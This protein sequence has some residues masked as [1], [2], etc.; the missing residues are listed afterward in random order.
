MLTVDIEDVTVSYP[1]MFELLQ[2]LG[3]M[4]ERN[5]IIGRYV[6]AYI[7]EHTVIDNYRT[8]DRSCIEIH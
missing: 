6:V 5:A 8:A 1:S 2:D 4:G 7:I 3:D